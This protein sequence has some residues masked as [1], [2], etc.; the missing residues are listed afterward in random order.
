MLAC[1]VLVDWQDIDPNPFSDWVTTK[2]SFLLKKLATLHEVPRVSKVGQ[3]CQHVDVL[4]Q[5]HCCLR[6]WYLVRGVANVLA[7][8]LPTMYGKSGKA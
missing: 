2:L 1:H 5:P 4:F 3:Q 7:A 8:C 6:R